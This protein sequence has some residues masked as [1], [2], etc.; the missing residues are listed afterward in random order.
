MKRAT[1]TLL[2]FVMFT[3]AASSCGLI[4][5][6]GRLGQLTVRDAWS[7]PTNA[8]GNGAVY[9]VIDNATNHDDELLSA[10]TAVASAAEFHQSK[11]DENGVMSMR[12]QASVPVPAG[13]QVEFKPGELHLMLVGLKED[14]AAGDR[15][16]VTLQFKVA[17]KVVL[18]VPVREQ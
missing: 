10:S 15:I 7:R 13:Q 1:I 2:L 3:L 9:F 14:L 17:G 8:G 5:G 12:P 6:I 4:P 18:E 11:M 16:Q